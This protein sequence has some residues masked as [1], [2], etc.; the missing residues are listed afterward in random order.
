MATN[1]KSSLDALNKDI[2]AVEQKIRDLIDQDPQIK[3]MYKRIASISG[4]VLT[5]L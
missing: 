3:D 5:A 2:Q 1:C 4:V